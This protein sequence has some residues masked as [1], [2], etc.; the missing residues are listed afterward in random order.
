M[1]PRRRR[2][3]P[4]ARRSSGNYG[5]TWKKNL[6]KAETSLRNLRKKTR[7]SK[8][9]NAIKGSAAVLAGAAASGAITGYGYPQIMGIDTDVALGVAAVAAGV[10][11]GKP[12]AILFGA[13]ALT[14]AVS[15]WS[16]EKA[17]EISQ[18]A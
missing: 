10:A 9:P 6:V 7:E 8:V 2:R 11:M 15:D 1:P 16:R 17:V 12:T 18:A 4:V 3:Y 13:G 5:R 14:T